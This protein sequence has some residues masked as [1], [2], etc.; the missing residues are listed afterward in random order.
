MTNSEL[1]FPFA[2]GYSLLAFLPYAL[3]NI[4]V[5]LS[6]TCVIFSSDGAGA[7]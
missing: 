6:I 5:A 3:R 4:R 7:A 1:A 2:I